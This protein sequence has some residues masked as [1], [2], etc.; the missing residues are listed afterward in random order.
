MSTMA[1]GQDYADLIAPGVVRIERLLPGPV[2]RIWSYL[3]D[4]DKRRLWM[5]SGAIE[6]C[7]GG[8]TE[9]VFRNSEIG[10]GEPPPAK[11]ASHAGEARWGGRVTECRPPTLLAYTWNEGSDDP[12]EVRFELKEHGDKVLLVVTHG[13]IAQRGLMTAFGAGWHTHLDILAALL[14]ER[15]PDGFWGKFTRLEA[16]YE[17]RIPPG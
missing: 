6:L 16:E 3:T 12:S 8:K 4:T 9:H 15:A 17:Q 13:Q 14:D 10:A 1:R 7:N 5:A 2:E 11:Y